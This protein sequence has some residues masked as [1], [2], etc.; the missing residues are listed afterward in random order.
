MASVADIC[1]LALNFVGSDAVIT[2][3]TPPDGTVEGG[4]CARF[5]PISRRLCYESHT[6]SW[7]KTRASLAQ[8]TNPSSVW[9]Y[10]Y[11][12]PSDSL[13]PLRVIQQSLLPATFPWPFGITITAD[14]AA[15]WT[16]RGSADF[17]IEGDVLLTNE[18]DAVL[19]YTRDDADTTKFSEQFVL[20][21]ALKMASFIAGPLVKG[22]AGRKLAIDLIRQAA[23]AKGDAA[24]GDANSSSETSEFIPSAVRAR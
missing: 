8:V 13:T 20:Y 14:E 22:D 10:A 3:I 17:E 1:N 5:Y 19:L 11:A 16:E 21:V 12:L 2:T 9:A 18:P 23:A 6:F 4:L 24:A 7:T 15:F